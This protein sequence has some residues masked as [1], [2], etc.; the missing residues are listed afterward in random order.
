[1]RAHCVWLLATISTGGAVS[2]GDDETE[3]LP[4]LETLFPADNAITGWTVDSDPSK[5]SGIADDDNGIVA[6]INGG[7][8]AFLKRDYTAFGL[9]QY[10]NNT[11]RMELRIWQFKSTTVSKEIYGAVTSESSSH[12]ASTWTDTAMGEAARVAETGDSFWYNVRKKVYLVE[13]TAKDSVAVG[14]PDPAC[15][16]AAEA[17]LSG[18]LAGMPK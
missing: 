15:K 8:E 13:G 7:A 4:K 6:L 5:K 2:C 9:K 17:F 3:T 12:A 11:Y 16:T 18:V 14:Q 1:M 10:K